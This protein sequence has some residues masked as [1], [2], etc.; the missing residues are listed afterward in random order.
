MGS[1][2]LSLPPYFYVLS[3]HPSI[4]VS[5]ASIFVS[6]D[7]G[8]S[9]RAR[10]REEKERLRRGGGRIER[11]R[12][13]ILVSCGG[14]REGTEEE[15]RKK[16]KQKGISGKDPGEGTRHELR[17]NCPGDCSCSLLCAAVAAVCPA[18]CFLDLKATSGRL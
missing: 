18:R 3:F 7:E 15:R 4:S 6:S 2:S 12:G 16:K 10:P 9:G 8:K 5:P 14:G 17:A 11:E 13:G 1:L